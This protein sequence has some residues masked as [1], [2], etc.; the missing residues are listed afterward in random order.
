MRPPN[1]SP[2]IR[3]LGVAVAVAVCVSL[4]GVLATTS[5]PHRLAA[6]AGD[7]A[8]R[9]GASSLAPAVTLAAAG[10]AASAPA[11]WS[12]T[13][14]ATLLPNYNASLPGNF[15]SLVDD[16]QV[17]TP[18]VVPSTGTVWWPE[19][20]VSVDGSPAP[21]SAPALLYNLSTESFVGIDQLV[22]NISA[23]AYD[24]ETKT[25]F[26]A[27]PINDTVEEVSPTTD[28][29]TGV[30]YR[31]G[32]A[33]SAIAL[34][35]LT[36]Y[37]FVANAGSSSVTII[38]PTTH[39]IPWANVPVGNDPIALADDGSDGWMYV[40][41]GGSAY[42]SRLDVSSPTEFETATLLQYGPVR[43]LSFSERSDYLAVTTEN[44]SNLTIVSGKTGA[45]HP[46]AVD[47]GAGFTAVTVTLN[48]STFV[49]ANATGVSFV[50]S[51]TFDVSFKQLGVGL[52]P[53]S[54]VTVPSNGSIL[55]WNN[56]TRNVSVVAPNLTGVRSP[57]STLAPEPSLLGYY[58]PLKR[59]YVA[60]AEL[61]GVE[62]LNPFTG[63]TEAPPIM[64]PSPPLSL[65]VD[66]ESRTLY[67]ALAGELLAY[68]VSTG[69]LNAQDTHLPG[70]NAPIAIDVTSGL[71]WVG[72][73]A[74][75]TVQALNSSSLE[76]AGP[77]VRLKVNSSSPA[78]L[79]SEPESNSILGVNS[80]SGQIVQFNGTDGAWIGSPVSAGSNVTALTWDSVDG[81][82]YAAGDG[83][84]AINP[85]TMTVV[86]P[87]TTLAPHIGVGGIAYETSREAIYVSTWTS[88]PYS[89]SLT[90]VNGSSPS[91]ASSSLTIVPTGFEPSS[92][93]AVEGPAES[94]P[95]SGIVL[96][97]NYV[98]G[99]IS[100]VASPPQILSASFDPAKVDENVSTRLVVAAVGGATTSS[101][102]FT[103]LPSGCSLPVGFTV[104]CSPTEEGTFD[105]LA[106]VT[107]ALGETAS[108][109]ASLTVW[110]ALAL[111][112]TVGTLASHE[113]DVKV[114]VAMS[115]EA[116]GGSSQY[117]YAW[118]FGDGSTASG[119]S[120]GHTFE[121][122][123]ELIVAVTATDQGGGKVVNETLVDVEADPTVHLSVS[124]GLTTD[125][126][127]TLELAALVTGG[128]GPGSGAWQFGDGTGSSLT[129]VGHAWQNAGVYEVNY[130]FTDALGLQAK[131][132]QSILVNPKLTGEFSVDPLSATPIVGTTFDFDA[133]LENGTRGYTVE[134]FFGDGSTAV[135][136]QV[137][138]A[139]SASGSYAVNVSALD[140]AGAYLN[141]SFPNIT[142]GAGPSR[143]APLLGG[144]FGP[145]FILGLVLGGAVAAVAL[146]IAERAR[147]AGP[148]GPPSPYVPPPPPATR[149]RS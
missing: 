85:S 33:P 48:G 143:A 79:I 136:A 13:T 39:T 63:V 34:D 82:V 64:L 45:V 89:G 11:S 65:T 72:R 43:G 28:A 128:A 73:S 120:V 88:N 118:N 76:S 100:V 59:L 5:G 144:G 107:D 40:G 54:L 126:D 32:L 114:P 149:G 66:T 61:P 130:T 62:I 37:L 41:N 23:L 36:G 111:T 22:T 7:A 52:H 108:A 97:A 110:S 2:T 102:A 146:F 53:T 26:A 121:A 93:V 137:T 86:L 99:T 142:V 125:V 44:G 96:A 46:V 8:V 106:T 113:V 103:G 50:N 90:I 30:V 21:T 94:L 81:L 68:N 20:P 71:L 77:V 75:G 15:R 25:L 117:T 58:A 67:V 1:R 49:V 123:G 119:A 60:D 70:A 87:S 141:E 92:L 115:A 95:D 55:V 27:D 109:G 56:G 80:T 84:S 38:D 29:P 140:A 31:V 138:H 6:T 134:W 3:R 133:T 135:G 57:A 4:S 69:L 98:S 17:G 129:T 24:P 18:A 9:P 122:T 83:L 145:S 101:V 42:L 131:A 104:S 105:V 139:Y 10:S 16:W 127:R 14:V 47:V 147:R 74:S 148:A 12:G 51:S 124:P 132:T 112:A 35:S 19:L 78:S 116:S 91:A